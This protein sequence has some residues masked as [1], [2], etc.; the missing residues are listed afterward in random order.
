MTA[1]ARRS[2][3]IMQRTTVL[4]DADCGFCRWSADRLRVWDGGRERLR[5]V[6]LRGPD[7]DELLGPMDE[8]IRFASWHV[9]TSDG[10]VR[11]A[12]AAV[13]PVMRELRGGTLPAIVAEAFPGTTERAYGWL[14]RHRLRLGRALGAQACD[15]DPS[16]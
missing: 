16:R 15:V 13:A 6:N 2:I 11:S 7:A 12:G 1:A 8:P 3:G 4:Y 14:V 5:F 10:R 9:V